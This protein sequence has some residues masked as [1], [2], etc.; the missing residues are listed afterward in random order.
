MV[1]DK[2]R[3]YLPP[4]AY[5]LLI[6]SASSLPGASVAKLTFDISD[7]IL[8]FIEY[9]F[10]G[11]TLIW[12]FLGAQAFDALKK[13]TGLA[14]LAGCLTAVLDEFYQS[15]IPTR[16]S[17]VYDV[18]ADSLGVLFSLATFLVLMKLPFLNRWRTGA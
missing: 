2:P 12:A 1:P 5:V 10:F 7:Y 4:I 18:L 17:S 16:F 3:F 15:F 13:A 14:I 6:L 9:N 8:H 11:V